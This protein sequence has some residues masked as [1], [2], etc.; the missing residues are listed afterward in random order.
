VTLERTCRSCG[1]RAHVDLDE[2]CPDCGAAYGPF[3]LGLDR[4]PAEPS[5]AETEEQREERF[6]AEQRAFLRQLADT[7][8]RDTGSV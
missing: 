1:H 8:P 5:I 6:E 2:V 3:T 7:T 4:D